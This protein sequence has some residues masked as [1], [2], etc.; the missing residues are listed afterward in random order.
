[1][2][3][4]VPLFYRCDAG[5]SFL[6]RLLFRLHHV[7]LLAAHAAPMCS[8]SGGPGRSL[9][10]VSVAQGLSPL[11]ALLVGYTHCLF[12]FFLRP[13]SFPYFSASCR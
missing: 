9:I 11:C 5:A 10:L 2:A 7:D 1:M 4:V 6:L 13:R 8:A 12:G 3:Q